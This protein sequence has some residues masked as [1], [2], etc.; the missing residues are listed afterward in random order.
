MAVFIIAGLLG[1][2][3]SLIRSLIKGRSIDL[4]ALGVNCLLLVLSAAAIHYSRIMLSHEGWCH[5][6]MPDSP[7]AKDTVLAIIFTSGILLLLF[8]AYIW[9]KVI[10][11]LK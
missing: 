1:T 8:N 3:Y 7:A 11:T 2:A 10:R 6:G 4:T 5:A 9:L